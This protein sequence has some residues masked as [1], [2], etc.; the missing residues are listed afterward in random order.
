MV[1]TTMPYFVYRM[2]QVGETVVKQLEKLD[3]FDAYRDARN[4]ARELRKN[5]P[6]DD[7]TTIKVIFAATEL[8]AEEQLMEKREKPILR[9]WEK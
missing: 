6:T 2:N 3:S 8:D 9:E 1:D 7:S 4:F 5:Q